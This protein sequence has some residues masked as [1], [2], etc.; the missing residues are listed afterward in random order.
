MFQK[1]FPISSHNLYITVKK[2]EKLYIDI[3]K[4]ITTNKIITSRIKFYLKICLNLKQISGY[5]FIKHN[6]LG[7]F[8]WKYDAVNV[9]SDTKGF[10]IK[11]FIND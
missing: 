2:Y 8:H 1:A 4:S 6:F 3:T 7:H 10:K 11:N 9:I 5:F